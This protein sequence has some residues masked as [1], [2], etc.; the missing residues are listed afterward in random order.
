MKTW[1]I[2]VVVAVV[3]AVAAGAGYFVV[4]SSGGDVAATVNG[5]AIPKSEIDAQLEV[6]KQ[7]QGDVLKDPEQE[8]RFRDQVLD[9]LISAELI[10]QEAKRQGIEV[11]DKE[12]DEKVDQIKKLFADKDGGFKKALEEQGLT[13]ASLREKIKDQAIG[14]KMME[15]MSAGIKVTNKDLK[16]YFDKN[17]AQFADPEQKRWSQIVLKTEKQAKDL[18][19]DINDGG[20]FAEIAKENSLDDRSK[21]QG[22]DI[23]LVGAF[24]L[25]PEL[26]EGIKDVKVSEVSGVVK[27]NDGRFY[28]FRLEEVKKEKQRSFA[29]VKEQVKQLVERNE[30]QAKFTALLEKLKA[31]AEIDKK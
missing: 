17:K 12:L 15:R 24:D 5:V 7:A 29:D 26:G 28:L 16:E 10:R 1:Q 3:L 31:D 2:G 25:P 19:A 27:G 18:L 13:E 20:D 6:I 23:G 30:Q 21:K 11:T 9:F 22:G 8:K 4:S 14:D